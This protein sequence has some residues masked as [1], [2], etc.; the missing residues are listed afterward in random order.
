MNLYITCL[1][2]C[3]KFKHKSIN[4]IIT[5]YTDPFSLAVHVN[6]MAKTTKAMYIENTTLF[7][8][9]F[10]LC[11]LLI[12]LPKIADFT[13]ALAKRWLVLGRG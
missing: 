2:C 8:N 10:F 7:N 4:D 5:L 3:L 1:L 11:L 13:T 6:I 12:V 9:H